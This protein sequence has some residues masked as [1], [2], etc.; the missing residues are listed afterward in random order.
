MDGPVL[1]VALL[2]VVIPVVRLALALSKHRARL[3]ELEA[4]VGALEVTTGQLREV[5]DRRVAPPAAVPAVPT[6][7][8]EPD[9]EDFGWRTLEGRLGGTWLSRVGALAVTIGIAFFL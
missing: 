9:S 5:R 8:S 2:V 4:R 7:T 1:L 6:A 3:R